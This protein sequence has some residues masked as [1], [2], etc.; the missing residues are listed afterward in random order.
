MRAHY[1]PKD[2]RL[3]ACRPDGY[4]PL[5]PM[6]K[7][8]TKPDSTTSRLMQGVSRRWPS[9]VPQTRWLFIGSSR[10]TNLVLESLQ[11]P[12]PA[13]VFTPLPSCPASALH[14]LASSPSELHLCRRPGPG[15]HAGECDLH[16]RQRE[17][18]AQWSV[19]RSSVQPDGIEAVGGGRS[20][21]LLL[22]ALLVF[23]S[24]Q[25]SGFIPSPTLQGSG[26]IVASYGAAEVPMQPTV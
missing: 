25:H 21:D 26:W 17:S 6:R 11:A 23:A 16:R 5:Q 22:V 14:A 10:S 20:S 24:L 9:R 2:W 1:G 19:Q 15:F 12:C 13:S 18:P 8:Q 4:L 7:L 3:I